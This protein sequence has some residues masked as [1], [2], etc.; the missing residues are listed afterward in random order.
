MRAPIPFNAAEKERAR[1]MLQRVHARLAQLREL[2]RADRT[3]SIYSAEVDIVSEFVATAAEAHMA[4]RMRPATALAIVESL[5]ALV[6]GILEE[7]LAILKA[8]GNG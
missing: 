7:R 4:G 3:P 8:A 5:D 6:A 1:V 2:D